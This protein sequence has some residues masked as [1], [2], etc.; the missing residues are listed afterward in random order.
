MKKEK[1][2]H[3]ERWAEQTRACLSR[4]LDSQATLFRT[5]DSKF[6]RCKAI[7]QEIEKVY[8]ER[9]KIRS[10]IQSNALMPPLVTV[11]YPKE[12]SVFFDAHYLIECTLLSQHLSSEEMSNARFIL[13][14]LLPTFL[15]ISPINISN[16]EKNKYLPQINEY[17]NHPLSYSTQLNLKGFDEYIKNFHPEF[18][19]CFLNKYY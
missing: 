14:F 2:A 17:E 16:E 11:S 4:S 6:V 1:I 13:K 8:E 7:V 9:A 18:V 15:C 10:T 5:N 12:M 19:S 3:K